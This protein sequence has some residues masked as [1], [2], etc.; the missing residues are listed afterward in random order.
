MTDSNCIII[1]GQKYKGGFMNID[2][3]SVCVALDTLASGVTNAWGADTTVLENAGWSGAAV[4]RH[5][6][7]NLARSLA[8]DIRST[9]CDAVPPETLKL[10]QDIPRRLQLVQAHTIPQMFAG[11]C[12]QA[13]PA[14][15][16]TL[17]LFRTALLPAIGWQVLPDPKS[18]PSSLAKRARAAQAEL[19]Q[20]APNLE[21][22]SKQIDEIQS[23]HKVADSLP[24]DLQALAVARDKVTKSSN[25]AVLIGE[26]IDE[27]WT[28]SHKRLDWMKGHADEAKKLIEQCETAYHI[29]T[30]K[31]LAGAFDQRAGTLAWSMWAWVGGLV[32][33]LVAGSYFGGHKIELLASSLQAP[34]LNWGSIAMQTVLSIFSIGAPLWF[35][36]ISTKQIGQRFRLAEDY[37][38]KASVAKAY[39]GYRKEAARID[40]DFE[41]RLFG[42]ALTRLEEAPLRLVEKDSHG[43]P[44]HELANS[45]AVRRACDSAPELRDKVIDLLREGIATT[46]KI[47]SK[48]ETKT[49]TKIKKQ[50]EEES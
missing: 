11:N 46:G 28:E 18:L 1:V 22:L 3:E 8:A 15:I 39:E 25:E 29:T 30:T 36:W 49:P 6:L 10:V 26:K 12:G 47:F 24:I 40:P 31:G 43:S 32:I 20:L 38:Y 35:A 41:A 5:E 14:Y 50:A 17:S 27:A 19:D 16:T 7:A 13:I 4:T 23:A 45:E 21:Q 9:D 2:L 42:S 44:W 48:N 34:N 33:A 37:A